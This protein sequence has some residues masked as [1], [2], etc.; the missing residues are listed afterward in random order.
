MTIGDRIRIKRLEKRMTQE[1]LSIIA[2]T[3][4]PNINRYEKN[5][6]TNIPLEKIE[7]IAEALDVSPTYLLGWDK[8]PSEILDPVERELIFIYR[9]ADARQKMR[10]DG[11]VSEI[12]KEIESID[13]YTDE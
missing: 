2:K 9:K 10:I 3:S 6:I 11:F 4:K 12:A 5:V 13:S 7:R 1:E 8:E